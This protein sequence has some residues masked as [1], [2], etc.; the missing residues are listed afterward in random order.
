MPPL[1]DFGFFQIE[2]RASET[3]D[4][5]AFSDVN[6]F[7]HDMNLLYEFSRVIVD[8]KYRDYRFS[9]FF[10]YR[11]RQRVE[12][13]DQLRLQSLTQE[14]PLEIAAIVAAAPSAAATIWILI[15]AFDK[16]SNYSLNRD[17][18]KLSRE[19]LRRELAGPLTSTDGSAEITYDRFA[20][21]VHIREAEYT[22]GKIEEHLQENPIRIRDVDV[23]YVRELPS[24]KE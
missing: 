8:P 20:K 5:P 6:Y 1:S 23:T 11:N 22:Y 9:R 12:P 14:S 4:Y 10:V 21:Q 19:K 17:I 13:D 18:L 15:Q 24:K 7:L 16:I 2:L 3:D